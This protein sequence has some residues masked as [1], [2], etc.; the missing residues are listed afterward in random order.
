MCVFEFVRVLVCVCVCRHRA[1]GLAVSEQAAAGCSWTLPV[2]LSSHL[3][4]V[5]QDPLQN[6]LQ[7]ADLGTDGFR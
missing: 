4:V 6:F 1:C 7:V 3:L 2:L 5:V